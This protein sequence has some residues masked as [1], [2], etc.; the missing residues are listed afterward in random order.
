MF[1]VFDHCRSVDSLKTGTVCLASVC[2]P[3]FSFKSI[4][5]LGCMQLFPC[6]LEPTLL[7]LP[8]LRSMIFSV[9]ICPKISLIHSFPD[10]F[11]LSYPFLIPLQYPM[12]AQIKIR[13]LVVNTGATDGFMSFGSSLQYSVSMGL[14]GLGE[15]EYSFIHFPSFGYY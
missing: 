2:L 1:W 7:V 4:L 13:P 12:H 6:S 5:L 15:R 11:A 8:F 3:V 9:P 14:G 10:L